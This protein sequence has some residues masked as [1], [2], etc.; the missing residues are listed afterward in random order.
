MQDGTSGR[1]NEWKLVFFYERMDVVSIYRGLQYRPP[2]DCA[3]H[4]FLEPKAKRIRFTVSCK[5]R[6]TLATNQ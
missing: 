1:K 5:L 2:H 3:S 6:S 4:N